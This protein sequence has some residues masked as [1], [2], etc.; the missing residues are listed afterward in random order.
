MT[1][2][3]TDIANDETIFEDD[4]V[5]EPIGETLAKSSI[6]DGSED[7]VSADDEFVNYFYSAKMTL[8][9][10]LENAE[11]SEERIEDC[12]QSYNVNI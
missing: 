9:T 4:Y 2:E 10:F 6:P 11:V 5:P 3:G 7:S 1:D 12:I 8:Q